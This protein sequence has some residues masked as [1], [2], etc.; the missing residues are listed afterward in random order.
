MFKRLIYLIS[1]VLVTSL[2]LSS[3]AECADPGL[4]AWYRFDGN[5]DDSSGND[6]HG[7]EMGGPTY[8]AGVFG[9]AMS[10]DGN[11]DYVDC[12]SDPKFDIIDQ[13]SFSYW[14][15]VVEFDRQW[16]T[17]FSRG[18]DSWRSS[19]AGLNNYMECGMRGTSGGTTS[20]A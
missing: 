14:I 5:A 16:N 4:V 17:V 6:L 18:D 19:R 1:F 2:I 11:D 7:T 9:Q 12:G 15:K 3:A 10:F 20:S 13:I 8:E